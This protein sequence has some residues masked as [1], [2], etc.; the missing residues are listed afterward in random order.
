MLWW[1]CL[2]AI[3][4][5]TF[6]KDLIYILMHT[7]VSILFLLTDESF[8][9]HQIT[10]SRSPF[11]FSEEF[12][13]VFDDRDQFFVEESIKV[14]CYGGVVLFWVNERFRWYHGENS[15]ELMDKLTPVNRKPDVNKQSLNCHPA[16]HSHGILLLWL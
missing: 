2:T 6:S 5:L 7:I 10:T 15:R 1:S 9:S 11:W 13:L 16:V 8:S 14:L 4:S 3:L 12:H